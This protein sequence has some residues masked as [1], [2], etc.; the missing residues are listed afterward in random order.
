MKKPL[1]FEKACFLLLAFLVFGVTSLTAQNV[2][3]PDPIAV[4]FDVVPNSTFTIHGELKMIANSIVGPNDIFVNEFGMNQ[5]YVPNDDYNG[6]GT[7]NRKTFGYIDIDQ[8]PTT[9]S[10]SSADFV[11]EN[12]G[13]AKV[14]YA[15]L[16]W[17]AA[18]YVDRTNSIGT[19]SD[20]NYARYENLPLPDS[21]P[22]FRT[23]KFK[24]PG[25]TNYIDIPTSSTTVLY[26]GYRNTV[27]NPND[28][29]VEDMPYVCYTDVT[30]I[31]KG[32]SDPDGTYTVANMRATT[33]MAANNSAGISGG[34]VLVIVY[35]DA[36]LPKKYISTN[37]GFLDVSRDNSAEGNKTF[38]YTGF[39][40]LPPPLPVNARYAIATLEGDFDI[41][42]DRLMI[43]KPDG[44]EASLF[45]SPANTS[46][47]FFDSSITVDGNYVDRPLRAPAS[48][49]TL[50]FDADIFDIPNQQSGPNWLIGND[51]T[52][53]DFRIT[54]DADRYRVFFNSF[55]VEVIEPKLSVINRVL[56]VNGVD[57]TGG[58]VYLADQLYYELTIQNQG[59]EDLTST[60]IKVAIPDE[61]DFA[62]VSTVVASPGINY[63]YNEVAREINITIDD[64]FVERFDGPLSFRY[65]VNVIADCSLLAE[66]CTGEIQSTAYSTYTGVIS[67]ASIG[68]EPSIIE[69]DV[70]NFDLQGPTS[71]FVDLSLCDQQLDVLLCG[72]SVDLT[73]GAGFSS[74]EWVDTSNPSVVLG[75]NQILTVTQPGNYKVTKSGNPGCQNIAETF[76]VTSLNGIINP[77]IDIVNNLDS[78]PN[79]NGNIRTCPITGEDLP[80]IF[81]CGSGSTIDLDSGF[82]DATTITW[83]RLDP[84]ACAAVIRDPNCPT[85][86]SLCDPEWTQVGTERVFTVSQAGEYRITAIFNS[87]PVQFYF[88]VFKNDLEPEA[89]VVKPIICDE[90]GIIEVANFSNQYEYQLVSP[91]GIGTLYQI[92]P[93][94]INLTEP[95][96]HTINSRQVGDPLCILQ[97]E[98]M[99]E[100]LEANVSIQAESPLCSGD[101]G[102]INIAVIDGEANYTYTITSSTGPFTDSVGPVTDPNNVFTG[103]NP[104]TY[105]VEVLS[106]DG[107]CSYTQTVAITPPIDVSADVVL[108]KELSCDSGNEDAILRVSNITGGSGNYEWSLTSTGVFTAISAD[109]LDIPIN[110]AGTYTVYIRNQEIDNCI[111]SL[112]TL[113]VDPLEQIDFNATVISEVSCNGD[114]D[115]SISLTPTG[116][117]PNATYNYEIIESGTGSVF[118][119]GSSPTVPIVITGLAAGSYIAR[120]VD[121]NTACNSLT[122]NVTV[123]EPTSIDINVSVT[124]PTTFEGTGEITVNATG[125]TPPYIYAINN[126]A[127]TTSNVFSLLAAGDYIIT[128]TD[129]NECPVQTNVTINP[130]PEPI[131]VVLNTE[132]TYITCFGLDN[133]SITSTVTGGSGVYSY[134]VQGTNYI[135]QVI[136]LGPQGDAFFGNLSA[137]NYEY[138]VNGIEVIPFAITQPQQ[139][140]SIVESNPVS[141]NGEDDG[142]IRVISSGG[143][144]PYVYSLY[145]YSGTP[146]FYIIEDNVD[147]LMGEHIFEGLTPG[148]YRVEVEDA[149]GCINSADDIAIIEPDPIV[150]S[151]DVTEVTNEA[152]GII[153]INATGGT[154]PYEY[155]INDTTFGTNNVFSDLSPATYPIVV[156]DAK[157]CRVVSLVTLLPAPE[158]IVVTLNQEN[159]DVLCFGDNTASIT[160]AVTGGSGTYTY[161]LKGTNYLGIDI[162]RGPQ[163]DAFFEG[164]SAGNYEY[165][166]N[167]TEATQFIVAQPES[168]EINI[169]STDKTCGD[170][171]QDGLI[172]V[173][174]A[175]G[176]S[177]YTYTL[178]L[179]GNILDTTLTSDTEFI[180]TGLDEGNYTIAIGDGNGCEQIADVTISEP[181]PISLDLKVTPITNDA[182]GTIE[183][184]AF[185][186]T[187][188]YTYELKD[189]QT[190]AV[191]FSQTSNIFRIGKPRD[192]IISVI[193]V[194]GCTIQQV[195]VVESTA[196]N[197]ILEYAD[198]I[199]FCAVTGKVYPTVTIEDANGEE[200]DLPFSGV[201]SIVWQKINDITCDIELEDDCPTTDSGCSSDWFNISTNLDCQITDPG[202]YRVVIEFTA[203]SVDQTQVFYFKA[204]NKTPSIDQNFA[205]YPNPANGLVKLNKEVKN[206]EVYDALGKVVIQTSQNTYDVSALRNGIYF[207]KVIT[208]DGEEII[209]RLI[210]K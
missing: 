111:F 166:V 92:A 67:F 9:F 113:T 75:T 210:R 195:V 114:S 192:Y 102:S 109:P 86:D 73:A 19:D 77:I 139:L 40:T 191:I 68:S 182:D 29:G 126:S 46:N 83:E 194:G 206:I 43:T 65:G 89:V 136:N 11:S 63:T 169:E 146:L 62:G 145:N 123:T 103:L 205:M 125:G 181:T 21:R 200:L 57:I 185:G 52:S 193:D 48:R 16:Y 127:P 81:L 34:W 137:G 12:P 177:P 31:V 168:L 155:S 6:P 180:F 107:D 116:N 196:Q 158:P 141:C 153:E 128:T 97:T 148:T 59:N 91:S 138:I 3:T 71:V 174:V 112:S 157:G 8:D 186:G 159:V 197:P 10:S 121:V 38:T 80:E 176:T 170:G 72:A 179:S 173:A 88:N 110:T 64:N 66:T 84:A 190:S 36:N 135:G 20:G 209:T 98:I 95:G 118:L 1:R 131:N 39:R 27:T 50:G 172:R 44:S 161:T 120:V 201:A 178:S 26:D 79:A 42:G 117:E 76:N 143:T 37:S 5:Q 167:D 150:S 55:Q 165:V 24:T 124:Q 175:G 33:G 202:Q 69:Q 49:N 187:A 7:N 93:R 4:P 154:P 70:C 144:P 22:D 130:A 41:I 2:A 198:E 53:V 94:F 133:A 189:A 82:V 100:A 60:S 163:N 105:E 104:D 85:I 149:I 45:T 32:L 115:G 142:N 14:A 87:C 78:T 13:C 56:D 122:N 207:V 58:N 23:L 203:K 61:V 106:F 151:L 188:P 134:S 208:Q 162:N 17:S 147:G 30:D 129:S 96:V 101:T 132:N 15:G 171:N 54:T 74:Y 184:N 160:S 183:I 90:A 18:Y 164:L 28:I 99:L 108:Y 119:A 35:E 156:R 51:Q 47:N 152:G 199:I 25:A 204:E 140:E